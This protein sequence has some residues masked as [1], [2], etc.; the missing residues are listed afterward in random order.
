MASEP[1]ADLSA[2]DRVVNPR[3]PHLWWDQ[4]LTLVEGCTRCSAGCKDC[5]AL[6]MEKRTGRAV[7]PIARQ[8]NG[9]DIR[10]R[11]DRLD[12]PLHWRKPRVVAVWNDLFHPDVP[13]SFIASA[14]A[15]MTYCNRHTFIV[16]TKR[17]RRAAA[18]LTSDA[19]KHEC[20]G[21]LDPFLSRDG[22]TWK[23]WQL[24][25]NVILGVTCEMDKYLSRVEE[26]VNTPAAVRFVNAHLL[27]PLDLAMFMVPEGHCLYC[28]AE[29]NPHQGMH[30]TCPDGEPN[31]GEPCGPVSKGAIDWLAIECNRPFKGDVETW[32]GWC[33]DLIRQA[34]AAGV[35][36]WAKQGPLPSGRVT[37]ELAEFPDWARRREFPLA[38]GADE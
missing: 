13:S 15:R 36:V 5:W 22:T 7:A 25:P 8:H 27:G 2:A 18:Y 34:D 23:D 29:C 19:G 14:F 38:K 30:W 31:M 20:W 16:L 9:T 35:K 28:G 12:E 3:K 33:L 32:W 17:A 10:L 24:P 4:A 21:H 11:R 37:H 1:R 26:L 6:A